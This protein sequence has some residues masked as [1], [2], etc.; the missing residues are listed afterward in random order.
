MSSNWFPLSWTYRDCPSSVTMHRITGI[1]KS[2]GISS[3]CPS[4]ILPLRW[5][6]KHK[7]ENFLKFPQDFELANIRLGWCP[8][9]NNFRLFI[10]FVF[11]SSATSRQEDDN[12]EIDWKLDTFVRSRILWSHRFHSFCSPSM[13]KIA[14]ILWHFSHFHK[15][16]R[17]QSLSPGRRGFVMF[18]TFCFCSLKFWWHHPRFHIQD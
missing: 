12:L 7:G 13:C 17:T 4:S 16:N 6:R 11:E 2:Y 9:L 18:S 1:S 8:T 14:Y 5:R 3:Q 10:P 15:Q